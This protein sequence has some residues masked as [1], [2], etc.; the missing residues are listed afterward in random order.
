LSRFIEGPNA[1]AVEVIANLGF[2]PELR[3]DVEFYEA[4]LLRQGQAV[5]V[6][7]GLI[8][9]RSAELRQGPQKYA[10]NQVRNIQIVAQ[11]PANLHAPRYW[12]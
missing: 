12:Y 3:L 7:N 6:T 5:L 4:W 2:D 8:S 10:D 1:L 9:P 11:G